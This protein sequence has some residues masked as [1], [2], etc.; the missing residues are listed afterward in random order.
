MAVTL[1]TDDQLF[2]LIAQEALLERAALTRES[3]LEDVGMTSLDVI[4]VL[5]EV[6]D[7]Y[8]IQ[9]E[10]SELEGAKTLGDLMDKLKAKAAASQ[11]A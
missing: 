8:G 6:E 10:E 5:F 9:M 2:D 7:K 11:E 3:S 1:P 4:S